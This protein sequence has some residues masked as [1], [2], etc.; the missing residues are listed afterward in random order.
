ME[1]RH[2]IKILP[3]VF[4]KWKKPHFPEIHSFPCGKSGISLQSAQIRNCTPWNK[5][6]VKITIIRC[7]TSFS[8]KQQQQ[9]QQLLRTAK[10]NNNKNNNNI[11]RKRIK[12]GKGWYCWQSACRSENIVPNDPGRKKKKKDETYKDRKGNE[13]F[14]GRTDRQTNKQPVEQTRTRTL[15]LDG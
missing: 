8:L 5:Q 2:P 1:E 4:R 6:R 13:S 7:E 12:T 9:Q 10:R 15:Y 11:K 14:C 3:P